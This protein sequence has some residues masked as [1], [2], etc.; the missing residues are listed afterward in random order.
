MSQPRRSEP[1]RPG[2][3]RDGVTSCSNGEMVR[4]G[5][6]LLSTI[7]VEIRD[8]FQ[9]NLSRVKNILAIY[10]SNT[11]KKRGRR[12]IQETDLLR[13]AVVLLHASLEDV[14][15]SLAEWKLPSA[16]PGSLADIPLA[17]IKRGTR[18]G[19]QELAMYRGRT[20]DEVISDSVKEHLERSSYNHPGEI[21]VVLERIGID[22]RFGDAYS[23][24]L[25]AM[26]SRRHWIAHRADRNTLRGS[27]H[28]SVKS[29]AGVVVSRWIE[30]VEKF[31]LDL[32]SRC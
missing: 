23:P 27:G 17:G 20:V 2:R 24:E 30:A 16:S 22:P 8:R 19:L 1:V 5:Y 11:G 29:L 14:L 7:A 25:A 28:H 21:K 32:L 6:G 15:R 4:E 9:A 13:G 18:I 26:M 31:G 10:Q 3:R 12:G